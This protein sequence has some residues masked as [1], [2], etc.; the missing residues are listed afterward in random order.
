MNDY[1]SNLKPF[2]LDF[3]EFKNALGIQYVTGAY[4]LPQLDIYNYNNGNFSVLKRECV[5][6]W[7]KKQSEKSNTRDRS[8]IS[9][10]QEFGRYLNS[11]GY[12]DAYILDDRYT[13]Q[14]YM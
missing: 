14:K 10:I 9:S 1:I 13:I 6:E 7:A 2:I 8:W 11:I 5:E 3:L 12:E 4:Y